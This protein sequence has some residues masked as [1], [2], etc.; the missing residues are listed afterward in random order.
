M[1]P[2]HRAKSVKL[3]ASLCGL[4]KGKPLRVLRQ[5]GDRNGL[6]VYGQLVQ[7]FTPTSRTRALSLLQAVMQF[8]RFTEVSIL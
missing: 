8:P 4:L 6:E 7:T 1:E 2:S 5:Q 3:C